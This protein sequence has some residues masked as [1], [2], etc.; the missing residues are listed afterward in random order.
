MRSK[1][2]D[3]KVDR[4]SQSSESGTKL[5]RIPRSPILSE[6]SGEPAFRA[7]ARSQSPGRGHCVA[8]CG[9]PT[10]SSGRFDCRVGEAIRPEFRLDVLVD[11]LK[12]APRASTWLRFENQLKMWHRRGGAGSEAVR[13]F[14]FDRSS[15]RRRLALPAV[16][17]SRA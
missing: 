6:F 8:R 12:P 14:G 5:L 4:C 17:P 2:T 16:E 13:F 15:R 10:Q 9:K 7:F 3:R 11:G 1:A